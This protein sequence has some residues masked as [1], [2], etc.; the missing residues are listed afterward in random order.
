[1]SFGNKHPALKL[2]RWET[3]A[4]RECVRPP[5]ESI[6]SAFRALASSRAAR[7]TFSCGAPTALIG[8][9]SGP[10]VPSRTSH[11]LRSDAP[12]SP[13]RGACSIAVVHENKR[14]TRK[15]S[16]YGG[17]AQPP[18]LPP[19]PLFRPPFSLH[20]W[21]APTD[22]AFALKRVCGMHAFN[23]RPYLAPKLPRATIAHSLDFYH[24]S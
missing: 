6:G 24:R 21:P 19:P 13:V 23:D 20:L 9:P 11:S 17:I 18:P 15:V 7:S 3:S 2:L 10:T 4:T 8:F 16:F 12:P 22:V 1:M 14:G 5:A